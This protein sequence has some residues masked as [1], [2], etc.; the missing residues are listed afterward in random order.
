[1]KVLFSIILIL[2][3]SWF[4]IAQQHEVSM[5]YSFGI[6]TRYMQPLKVGSASNPNKEFLNYSNF[7]TN[8]KN[9]FRLSYK[10]LF[11]KKRKV[12]LKSNF[13]Y[14]NVRYNYL[15]PVVTGISIDEIKVN[16]EFL[17]INLGLSKRFNIDDKLSFDIGVS[18]SQRFSPYNERKFKSDGILQSEYKP[19]VTYFYEI[20][21]FNNKHLSN[22]PAGSFW[23]SYINLEYS[24]SFNYK[25]YKNLF[26][27]INA[28]YTRNWDY[29]IKYNM[30]VQETLPPDENGITTIRITSAKNF[31]GNFINH[32]GIRD[33][34]LDL[35]IGLTYSF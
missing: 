31:G 27:N 34:F 8:Y 28:N 15:M 9:T 18:Y 7:Q 17:T 32:H 33:H 19:W 24:I 6:P 13:S 10:Y 3:L 23:E 26:L 30:V 4:A 2:Q 21:I 1:M 25:I 16:N 22:P 20:D 35:G 12:F 14:N 5:N 29:F 11:W